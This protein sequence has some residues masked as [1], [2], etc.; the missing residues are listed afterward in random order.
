MSA[1]IGGGLLQLILGRVQGLE[2][3][4]HV[5]LFGQGLATK[6]A[7]G[8]QADA[9]NKGYTSRF[10]DSRAPIV[11]WLAG[12][13]TSSPRFP[14]TS[15]PWSKEA[16]VRKLFNWKVRLFLWGGFAM[17]LALFL[18]YCLWLPGRSYR[19][20]LPA[21]D[22][23][24]RQLAQSIE[25]SV[26]KLA[27]EIGERHHHTY[28]SQKGGPAELE[29]AADWIE[30]QFKAA[31]LP[32]ERQ[33]YE[34]GSPPEKFANLI[35]TRGT[36]QEVV[37]V[38]AHYDSIPPTPGADDNAS[39]T[40]ILLELARRF[41]A[42]KRAVRFVAFTNEEPYYFKTEQMGSLV[43]ARACRQRGD[44][45]L[46]MLSLE[47]LGYYKDEPGSQKYPFPLGLLYPSQGN[48]V[49]FVS[50]LPSRWLTHRALSTFRQTTPF[51]SE[52]ACLPEVIPGVS[53]SDHWS[54]GQVGYPA[55]MVTDTAPFRNPHY[56]Q[57]TDKPE[58][59][60]YE[61]MARVTLGLLKVLE[62]LANR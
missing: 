13:S 41:Q 47:T 12:G 17:A 19:G 34:A 27:E 37:V 55:V 32:V 9:G 45:I 49:G 21:A 11:D 5:G 42:G 36:S 44:K 8:K 10:Q 43:Y 7:A 15:R 4:L 14:R 56:H 31:G 16:C 26:R 30:A 54:F 1:L 62:D 28:R 50:N 59:L 57:T 6:N 38:G 24:T 18:V 52:G 58:T 51:P 40:A 60:D 35:A 39:G 61:R 29:E 53:W 22:E 46:A 20:D 3:R 25:A 48:F 2:G 33:E 23:Q